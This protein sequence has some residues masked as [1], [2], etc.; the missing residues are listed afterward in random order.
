[1]AIESM[2]AFRPMRSR[3]TGC[4]LW[5]SLLLGFFLVAPSAFS[6][7]V[8]YV[9]SMRGEANILDSNA[10]P[11]VALKGAQ[12]FEGNILETYQSSTLQL[13]LTDGAVLYLSPNTRLLVEKFHY[14][15]RPS[16]DNVARLFLETGA[17]RVQTGP[18]SADFE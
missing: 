18:F 4:C 7:S 12:V 5:L 15:K 10:A 9:Q 17:V 6:S 2:L 3:A 11:R 1:M 16:A 13:R 8:G 14:T